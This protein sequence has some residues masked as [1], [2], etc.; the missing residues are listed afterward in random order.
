MRLE[1]LIAWKSQLPLEIALSSTESE[2]AK[3]SYALRGAILIMELLK[4]VQQEGRVQIST[5][6]MQASIARSLRTTMVH[7]KWQKC[8][9]AGQ[10]QSTSM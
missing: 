3:M 1:C 9:S 7:R 5:T 8:K 4:E 10:E 6:A 2:H